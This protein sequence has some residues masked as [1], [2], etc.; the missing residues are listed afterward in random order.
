[1]R[2]IHFADAHVGVETHSRPITSDELN[3]LPESF[4]PGVNRAATYTGMPSRLIDALR[5]L[6]ELV[7]FALTGPRA[8]LVVFSGDAYRSRDP[9]Q[10]HQREFARRISRLGPRR[11]P[12]LSPHRKP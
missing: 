6:D 8:D 1:M 11:N 2:I 10:T 12:R 5:A 3:T 7:D 4:A 9:S